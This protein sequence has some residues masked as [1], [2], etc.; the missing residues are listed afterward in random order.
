MKILYISNQSFN[1]NKPSN[2][3]INNMIVALLNNPKVDNVD[4]I[5]FKYTFDCLSQI[6]KNKN[7]Y[8]IV[9]VH[10]GGLYAFLVGLILINSKSKKIITF[11]GTEIHGVIS[12]DNKNILLKFKARINRISSLLS[13]NLYDKIGFVSENLR[14]KCKI[15]EKN[16]FIHDLGVNYE[17]FKNIDKD[18][19]KRNLSLDPSSHYLLFSSISSNPVKRYDIALEILSFLPNKYKLLT[20]SN[21]PYSDVP[22]YISASEALLITSDS[23][24]SPN[25]V[26]EFLALNKPVYSFDVGN[27]KKYLAHT[28]NSSIIPREPNSAALVIKNKLEQL[29]IENTRKSM[30]KLISNEFLTND[31]ITI[32]ENR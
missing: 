28:E 13:C 10:F 12:N 27:V 26:R 5:S 30:Q 9:H 4:F 2:P 1:S 24:G 15:K 23:E 21:T 7:N 17:T 16:H 3:I 25:I 29:V 22:I 20:M 8:N 6:F 11:H 18:K 31:L 19:A 14:D 32:Y